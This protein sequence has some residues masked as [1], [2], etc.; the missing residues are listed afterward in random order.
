[1]KLL[2]D[3]LQIVSHGWLIITSFL[4][5][6]HQRQSQHKFVQEIRASTLAQ[7]GVVIVRSLVTFLS[8]HV[9]AGK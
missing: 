4:T 9:R 8:F 1:M 5:T 6:P 7:C 2:L 3:H